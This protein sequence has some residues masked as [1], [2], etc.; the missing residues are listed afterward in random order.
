MKLRLAT[1]GSTLALRQA[2]W[3]KAALER[4]LHEVE[5]IPISTQGDREQ[6]PFR[7]L[8]GQG[9]FTKAVQRAVLAGEADLAVHSYK[10]LPSAPTPGLDIVAVPPR[11]DPR[12]VLLL[13]PEQS[14]PEAEILPLRV[15]ASVGTSAA[16][17]Q[18]QLRVL[19]PDVRVL[20]LR[21]NVPT[22]V[23]KLR[24]GAYDAIVLAAAGLERLELDPTDLVCKT[25][26]P[27]VLVPAPAQGALALEARSG[28]RE[29]AAAFSDLHNTSTAKA[30]AAER[31]LLGRIEGGCQLP[32]GAYATLEGSRVNFIAWYEGKLVE[33][34]GSSPAVAAQLAFEAL[35]KPHPAQESA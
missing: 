24:D 17:R 20:E 28:D 23:R 33:V 19:R 26:E 13:R 15:G 35:G 12:D 30:V 18:A 10:D 29:V 6:G 4:R 7:T 9:F 1:R 32:L 5:L 3:V 27:H 21:G 2:G 25:L 31:G 8:S 22:R 14:V 34:A 11:A 16:R